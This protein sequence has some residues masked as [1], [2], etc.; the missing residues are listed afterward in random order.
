MVVERSRRS[1]LLC[2]RS[3]EG[4]TFLC[5][6]CS[7]AWRGKPIPAE[8]RTRFYEALDRAYPDRSN[9]YGNWNVPVMLL[10]EIERLPRDLRVLELGAGGGF[11]AVE[12]A[13]EALP[14]AMIASPWLARSL[15]T[16]KVPLPVRIL[17]NTSSPAS[18][19]A[20]CCVAPIWRK[21]CPLSPL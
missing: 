2:G 15:R 13:H 17:M 14:A 19:M 8:V 18:P 4:R 5:R 11:F 16:L 3:F 1:C 20:A 6:D 12:G 10:R 7:D 21:R 9:T